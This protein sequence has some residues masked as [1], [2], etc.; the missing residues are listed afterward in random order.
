[1][2]PFFCTAQSFSLKPLN[3]NT[4]T[5]LRG[6]NV[7]SDQVIWASGSNGS[8]GK[9]EDGGLT[10]Q[11]V[12]PKGY[13]KLDFRD[14][15]AFDQLHAIIV[16]AGSPAYVLKTDDGGATWTEHYKNIDS[17]IFLDGL[18][19]WNKN[20]GIIFGDP[21][22]GKMQLL[23]TTD[24]GKTWKDIS[25]NLKL[26]LA[27]GEAGFAA[28]GTTIKTLSN[29]KVWI[30]SGGTVSNIYFS[31]NYGENWSVF[32]CPI[33]QGE[34]TTG[35][36]SIDFYDAK[37]GIVVGGNYVKNKAN[38]NNVLLTNDGGKTW[39]KPLT[40]VAGFRSAVTYLT[41]QI[42]VATGTSGTDISTDSGQNWKHISDQSFNAVQKA[43]KGNRII[44]A[45]EKGSI[46]ELII[47]K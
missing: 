22:R 12:K 17:A 13:E 28:S 27:E 30:A 15:E 23:K 41:K 36:F 19:F 24:A 18:G 4:K 42:L 46:F 3:E 25:S 34:S 37:N 21:I 32:K 1:M 26:P 2:A 31:N 5:S 39:K 16:N 14:I 40:P 7:V 35:P 11:W 43:G 38:D 44:M 8:V 9:T 47:K 6:L 33:L 20:N 45:G 10:W 29:G